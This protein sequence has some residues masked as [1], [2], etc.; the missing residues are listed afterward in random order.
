MEFEFEKMDGNDIRCI[1]RNKFF[2]Q[3]MEILIAP[4]QRDLDSIVD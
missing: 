3:L 1:Y 4:R 2:V